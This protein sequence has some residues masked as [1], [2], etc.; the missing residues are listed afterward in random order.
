MK[1]VVAVEPCFGSWEF[2]LNLLEGLGVSGEELTV[3]V[4]GAAAPK[5]V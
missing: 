1:A 4:A 5:P 2:F 3:V